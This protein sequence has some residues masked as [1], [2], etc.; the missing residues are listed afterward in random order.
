MPQCGRQFTEQGYLHY[1][2]NNKQ[3]G[4]KALYLTFS[5]DPREGKIELDQKSVKRKK[6]L[7]F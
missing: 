1:S 2:E 5:R 7:L 3:R 4:K 6:L